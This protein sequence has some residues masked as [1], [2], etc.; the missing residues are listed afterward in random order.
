MESKT[1]KRRKL[2]MSRKTHIP[3]DLA[4]EILARLPAKPLLRLKCVLSWHSEALP[5]VHFTVWNPTT[6]YFRDFPASSSP[7]GPISD[8]FMGF[9]YDSDHDDYKV[10]IIKYVFPSSSIKLD[11]F[12]LKSNKWKRSKD[13]HC[14][15]SLDDTTYT[16]T[17]GIMNWV[18]E[19][20][21]NAVEKFGI[22]SF[23]LGKE[24]FLEMVPVPVP[25][26]RFSGFKIQG[27]GDD[28]W[29]CK[30][31][32]WPE[33]HFEGWM[34]KR[35]GIEILWTQLYSFRKLPSREKDIEVIWVAKNG[36][37]VFDVNGMKLVLYSPEDKSSRKYGVNANEFETPFTYMETLVSPKWCIQKPNQQPS[38][39]QQHQA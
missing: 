21:D 13:V 27:V 4:I 1:P 26:Q 9:G 2:A 23:D 6:G 8:I 11:V 32:E 30:N 39:D 38:L 18:V 3:H 31:A 25:V 12:S 7:L 35:D 10:V 37:V 20:E 29:L 24:K 28:V 17:N 14:D 34:M 36:N 33:D 22:V 5:D 19:L 15:I 16:S